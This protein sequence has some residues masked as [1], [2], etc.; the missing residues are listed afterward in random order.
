M[1]GLREVGCHDIKV[2]DQVRRREDRQSAC[3]AVRRIEIQYLSDLAILL[4]LDYTFGKIRGCTLSKV[5]Y[6]GTLRM[7]RCRPDAARQKQTIEKR[8][9]RDPRDLHKKPGDVNERPIH[10]QGCS[11]LQLLLWPPS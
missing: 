11:R 6:A 1:A 7:V 9:V 5:T 2:N 8:S 3:C 10:H 4:R